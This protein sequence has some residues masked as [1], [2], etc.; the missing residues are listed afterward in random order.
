MRIAAPHIKRIAAVLALTAASTSVFAQNAD[1]RRGYDDGYAAGQRAARDHRGDRNYLQIVEAQYYARRGSCDA[2]KAVRAA[3]EHDRGSVAATDKLCGNPQAGAKK[4][5][6]VVYRCGDGAP[7]RTVT[8][9]YETL[10]M[11]CRRS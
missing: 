3:I 8:P 6:R 1:Y 11:S 2:R 10:R 7:V 5:L 4:S 9:Q